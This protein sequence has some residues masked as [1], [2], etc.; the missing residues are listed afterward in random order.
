MEEIFN[1]SILYDLYGGLL[2]KNQQLVYEYHVND[3]LSFTEIGEELNMT[4]QAAYDLFKNADKKLK[5]IDKK[6]SLS[7]RFK[8]IEIIANSINDIASKNY[9][10]SNNEKIINLSNKIKNIIVKGGNN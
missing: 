9:T 5:D 10:K 6:L 7:S 1:K 2:S 3:D 8:D 4:R